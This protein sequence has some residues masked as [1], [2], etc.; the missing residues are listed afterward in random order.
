MHIH[1]AEDTGFVDEED[2]PLGVT[3]GAKDAVGSGY[4][5]MGPEIAEDGVVNP[6]RVLGTG[7][8][9]GTIIHT[10]GQNLRFKAAE[11]VHFGFVRRD[12]AVT[13][14]GE[15]QGEESQHDV[16]AAQI[17]QGYWFIQMGG[18]GE[19]GCRGIDGERHDE[20]LLSRELFNNWVTIL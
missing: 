15:G 11:G 10:E 12:L 2:G 4:G 5:T 1:V 7:F 16:L 17:A 9:T 18:Q 14:G 20:S 3:L 6:D 8:L 19:I 13:H